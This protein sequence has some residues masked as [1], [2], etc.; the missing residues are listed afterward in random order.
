MEAKINKNTFMQSI[1]TLAIY[2]SEIQE[3][4]IYEDSIGLRK[5]IGVVTR[6]IISINL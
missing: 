4:G 1:N 6:K 3:L 5:F 2:D